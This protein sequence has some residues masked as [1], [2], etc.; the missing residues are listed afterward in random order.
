MA[1]ENEPSSAEL[2][3]A[4]AFRALFHLNVNRNTIAHNRRNGLNY[5]ALSC[6]R[7]RGGTSTNGRTILIKDAAGNVVARLVQRPENPLPC[8]ATVYLECMYSP[9][10][11][12]N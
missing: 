12:D 2:P 9:E 5:P 4:R 6:R 1:N 7:G 11:E 8:G 3:P 10:V